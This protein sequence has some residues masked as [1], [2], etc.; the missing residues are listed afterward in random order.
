MTGPRQARDRPPM[1]TD[2]GTLMRTVKKRDQ[3]RRAKFR[4]RL[5]A[6]GVNEQLIEKIVEQERYA[7]LVERHGLEE[8]RR[9]LIEQTPEEPDDTGYEPPAADPLLKGAARVTGIAARVVKRR[10][11]VTRFQYDAQREGEK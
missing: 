6:E 2:T 8:A 5:R 7:Q 11:T 3:R 9:I 10:D 1:E 4:A